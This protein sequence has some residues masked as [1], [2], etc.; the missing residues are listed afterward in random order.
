MNFGSLVGSFTGQQ[1]RIEARA[2]TDLT[3]R[4]R[5]ATPATLAHRWTETAGLS[6]AANGRARTCHAKDKAAPGSSACAL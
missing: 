5:A 3:L 2:A 6:F 4:M 1:A